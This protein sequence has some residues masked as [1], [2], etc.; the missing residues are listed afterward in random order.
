MQSVCESRT[1]FYVST[2]HVTKSQITLD[3]S[4]STQA[5]NMKHNS[6]AP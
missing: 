1:S 6:Q 4:Q 2:M 5:T 3:S